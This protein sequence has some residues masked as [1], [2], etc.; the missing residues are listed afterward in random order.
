[1]ELNMFQIR[2][3][4]LEHRGRLLKYSIVDNNWKDLTSACNMYGYV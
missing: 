3:D 4:L 1:M 2:S